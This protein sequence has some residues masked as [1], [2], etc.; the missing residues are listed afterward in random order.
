M[1]KIWLQK[2]A[3]SNLI[4]FFN[5]WGMD[6]NGIT[7]LSKENYDVLTIHDYKAIDHFEMNLHYDKI[8]I[9]AW[10]FGV[11]V[12]PQLFG[13]KPDNAISIAINGTDEPIHPKYGI[14]PEIF[15][16]TLQN[17]N[18]INAQKF[19]NRIFGSSKIKT[20]Y[21]TLL[22][23]REPEEQKIELMQLQNLYLTKKN[24]TFTWDFAL[25]GMKDAI[26]LP[27]NQLNFWNQKAKVIT[28]D[29]PH[30][31]F[32]LFNSWNDVINETTML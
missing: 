9:I 11:F 8:I 15:N 16:S 22:P 6:E 12:A 13:T 29:W 4:I 31:P 18:Q 27:D 2:K 26:F 5:G 19:M 24:H 20:A 14:A 10:S 21:S 1:K 23:Q 28:K 3:A 30:L 32:H 7:H 25:I 17:W